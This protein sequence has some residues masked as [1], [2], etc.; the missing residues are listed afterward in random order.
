M[1]VPQRRGELAQFEHRL[2]PLESD[3]ASY[4]GHASWVQGRH[5]L[6]VNRFLGEHSRDFEQYMSMHG[7]AGT[8]G[9]CIP[10]ANRRPSMRESSAWEGSANP[11]DSQYSMRVPRRR[12]KSTP[13]HS[14]A[15]ETGI[16][17]TVKP[18]SLIT[19]SH[20]G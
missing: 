7:S 14:T 12:L 3:E 17:T 20:T 13:Y 19:S 8:S 5:D 9:G 16:S 18:A 2:A 1:L 6:Q 4:T 11:R 10:A 15:I